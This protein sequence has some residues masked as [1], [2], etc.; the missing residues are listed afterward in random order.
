MKRPRRK[1]IL[2]YLDE[3][4]AIVRVHWFVIDPGGPITAR[5]TIIGTSPLKMGP[6][7]GYIAC[8]PARKC[9]E[10]IHTSET[11]RRFF[12]A[13]RTARRS[14]APTAWRRHSTGS[15]GWRKTQPKKRKRPW[16]KR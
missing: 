15:K 9:I 14:T 11:R 4:K 3:K 12:C 2:E 6:A 16:P 1:V 13:R 10:P 7:R 8:Q 5:C